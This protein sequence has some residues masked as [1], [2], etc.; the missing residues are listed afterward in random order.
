MIRPVVTGFGLTAAAAGGGGVWERLLAAEPAAGAFAPGDEGEALPG[1]G[2]GDEFRP[3]PGIPRNVVHFLDRGSLLALDAALRALDAAGLGAG[4]GD[5]RRFGVAEG[6]PMR[7]PGQPG[8][9]APYG[10]L[11]ARVLGVRGPVAAVAGGEASGLAAVVQ[12]ARLVARGEAD[13]VIAGAAQALQRPLLEHL[14]GM[15]AARALPFDRE[16]AGMVPA[17]GAA[18]LV[19]ESE[20]H[21]RGRGAAI[22]ARIAGAAEVFDPAA[23]PTALP[24]A[25]EA[26]R[27]MQ[28]VLADAGY[29]QNQVDLFV[30]CADGRP[31]ADVADGFGALRTF[32]RHAYFADVTAPAGTLGQLLAAGGPAAAALAL[33]AMA[34]GEVWPVAGLTTPIEGLELAFVKA[35]KQAKVDCALV[36]ALG[37]GGAA[38]GILLVREGN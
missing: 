2:F 6:L 36:T 31:E 32:G 7:A 20:A 16:H 8:I 28:A 10:Q 37:T 26:G 12:A 29:L 4:A 13:I 9:F 33:E 22:A 35:A 15:S 24:G 3:H 27:L 30:S 17:E 14:R 25:N 19:I 21:A 18:F 5:A 34:R 38:A 11:I 23:E 1:I